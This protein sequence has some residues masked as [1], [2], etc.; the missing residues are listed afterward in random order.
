MLQEVEL[1]TGNPK[2]LDY[3][4][5]P[6]SAL[7]S[8]K[9]DEQGQTVI[10][11]RVVVENSEG[12]APFNILQSSFE[13]AQGVSKM[14]MLKKLAPNKWFGLF[15]QSTFNAVMMVDFWNP[16]YSVSAFNPHRGT[17]LLE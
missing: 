14:Q 9:R 6:L 8:D 12:Q 17:K 11:F 4:E 1:F 7:G 5:L 13:D 2:P 10:G 15:S 16:I 3:L